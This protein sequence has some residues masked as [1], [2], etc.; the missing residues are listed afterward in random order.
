MVLEAGWWKHIHACDKI[1]CTQRQPAPPPVGE[2]R[3]STAVRGD[4]V[5][6][7]QHK[8][9]AQCNHILCAGIGIWTEQITAWYKRTGGGGRGIM[10]YVIATM[11][12][13]NLNKGPRFIF[14]NRLSGSTEVGWGGECACVCARVCRWGGSD[15]EG[16]VQECKV[17]FLS[18]WHLESC[19][20]SSTA[21]RS[22]L[23]S[24]QEAEVKV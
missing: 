16:G 2:K 18:A 17:F 3:R 14:F 7:Q 11:Q 21:D 19:A 10:N 12:P 8:F 9:E 23:K 22:D 6:K 20:T 4:L 24:V 5:G 13:T 1:R 15:S